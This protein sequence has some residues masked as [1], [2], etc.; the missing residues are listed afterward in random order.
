VAP[1]NLLGLLL[2][3]AAFSPGY[4]YLRFAERWHTRPARSTLLE[5]VELV[6]IGALLSTVVALAVTA[7]GDVTGWL[8]TG[9]L[10]GDPAGYVADQPTR[11]LVALLVAASAAYALAALAA[12]AVNAL[13]NR[14]SAEREQVLPGVTV[15]QQ[16]LRTGR[17]EERNSVV[18][19]V[20]LRDGR[21][22]TGL[23]YSW[24]ANDAENRE[25]ALQQT[26]AGGSILMRK[27][28]GAEPQPVPDKFVVLREA[29]I[30]GV[31]GS[32]LAARQSPAN[33]ASGE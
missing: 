23:A 32:W 11:C 16:V 1:K 8:D 15:W 5:G 22:L 20:E 33:T 26:P 2:L 4:V 21:V 6:S 17:P 9:R 29:D 27:N 12:I 31:Y 13:K 18:L 30:L 3:V 14:Q 7:L 10:F 24:T 28:I 19:N 25:L